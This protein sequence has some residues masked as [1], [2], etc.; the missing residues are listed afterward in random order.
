[1]IVTL[2]RY[3]VIQLYTKYKDLSLNNVL[4][5]IGRY[6]ACIHTYVQIYKQTVYKS[7]YSILHWL[8]KLFTRK[9]TSKI[10]IYNKEYTKTPVGEHTIKYIC[11]MVF[12]RL[13][14]VSSFFILKIC[15]EQKALSCFVTYRLF[16]FILF[17][18]FHKW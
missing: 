10:I 14:I 18:Y 11:I 8:E 5:I 17:D 6:P 15:I 16:F 3:Y 9:K 7:L 12:I 4:M 13:D 2:H 1:M